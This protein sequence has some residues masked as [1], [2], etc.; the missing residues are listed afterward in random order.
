MLSII[1]IL[2]NGF[3]L[4]YCT[5]DLIRSHNYSLNPLTPTVKD[6]IIISLI[7]SN[8]CRSN[9]PSARGCEISSVVRNLISKLYHIICFPSN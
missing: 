2:Y 9:I 7:I 3:I 4:Y 6:D 5:V 1:N 8:I